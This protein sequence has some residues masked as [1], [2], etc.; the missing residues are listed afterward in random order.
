MQ[1]GAPLGVIAPGPYWWPKAT[2]GAPDRLDG[3]ITQR[4][5]PHRTKQSATASTC[6]F[7]EDRFEGNYVE[8]GF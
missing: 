6:S 1:A 5:A 3:A 2:R 4:A 8:A 7:N